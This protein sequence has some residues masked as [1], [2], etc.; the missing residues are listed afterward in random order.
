MKIFKIKNNNTK[1]LLYIKN[2]FGQY[3]IKYYQ[4]YKNLNYY[5]KKN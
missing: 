1:N 5:I 3:I 4:N 2:H